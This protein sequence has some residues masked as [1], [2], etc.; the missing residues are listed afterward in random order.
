VACVTDYSTGWSLCGIAVNR[1]DATA[2][3]QAGFTLSVGGQGGEQTY[4]GVVTDPFGNVLLTMHPVCIQTVFGGLTYTGDLPDPNCVQVGGNSNTWIP[5]ISDG[6]I[7][8][9]QTGQVAILLG[10]ADLFAG[11]GVGSTF[12]ADLVQGLAL[13]AVATVNSGQPG[14]ETT[15]PPPGSSSGGG[16]PPSGGGGGGTGGTP[17][18]GGGGGTK[19]P[20]TGS[21]PPATSPGLST[22]EKAVLV[23][24]GLLVVV[25]GAWVLSNRGG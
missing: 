3:V 7:P 25:G 15:T 13:S 1:V 11:Y 20:L 23:G 6:D 14:Q 24:A 5:L 10:P 19:P 9:A 4:G 2:P 18:A 8:A 17:P 22:T 16:T 21:N 12:P